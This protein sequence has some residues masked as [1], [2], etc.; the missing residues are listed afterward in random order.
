MADKKDK[1]INPK[2]VKRVVNR[3]RKKPNKEAESILRRIA[4]DPDVDFKKQLDDLDD[5][6][7]GYSKIDDT[8]QQINEGLEEYS[9]KLG[10]IN[11]EVI[12]HAA[13]LVSIQRQYQSLSK[14][15]KGLLGA[16]NFSDVYAKASK[17]LSQHRGLFMSTYNSMTSGMIKMAKNA[18]VLGTQNFESLIGN[19]Q[20]LDR[21]LLD[22]D[23]KM[24]YMVTQNDMQSLNQQYAQAVKQLAKMRSQYEAMSQTDFGSIEEIAKYA[25]INLDEYIDKM[26][27][28]QK[29]IRR[30]SKLRKYG[31]VISQD[32]LKAQQENRK[33]LG[34]QRQFMYDMATLQSTLNQKLKTPN[35]QLDKIGQALEGG[36]SSLQSFVGYIGQLGIDLPG[37]QEIIRK[38]NFDSVV[39]GAKRTLSETT[40]AFALGFKKIG[41]T[42]AK[43]FGQMFKYIGIGFH[44]LLK[45]VIKLMGSILLMLTGG[46]IVAF[47]ALLTVAMKWQDELE[48]AYISTQRSANALRGQQANFGAIYGAFGG[49]LGGEKA[50]QLYN[51]MRKLR[52]VT[53][54]TA[55]QGQL[56]QRHFSVSVSQSANMLQNMRYIYGMTEKASNKYA[57]IIANMA[58]MYGIQPVKVFSELADL[59]SEVAL[60]FGDS[61]KHLTKSYFFAKKL[62]LTMDDL[63]KTAQ[64]LM[65]I[66]GTIQKS[67][68][69]QAL[70]GKRINVEQ[71]MQLNFAGRTEQAVAMIY[72]TFADSFDRMSVLQKQSVASF[73]STDVKT[74]ATVVNTMKKQNISASQALKK[75]SKDAVDALSPQQKALERVSTAA[76][77][78]QTRVQALSYRIQQMIHKYM[79]PFVDII[80]KAFPDIE[81]IFEKFVQTIAN[82]AVKGLK[83]LTQPKTKQLLDGLFKGV[84]KLGKTL[85]QDV[86][87]KI[88]SLF[89]KFIKLIENVYSKG[90]IPGLIGLAVLLKGLWELP[91]VIGAIS[92]AISVFRGLGKMTKTASTVAQL[93]TEAV[94]DITKSVVPLTQRA[95]V[96]W[97]AKSDMYRYTKGSMVGKRKVGGQYYGKTLPPDIMAKMQGVQRPAQSFAGSLGGADVSKT[98]ANKEIPITQQASVYWDAKSDMY[99]YTKGSMVGKRKVGGQ[100]YGKTLPPDIMAKMQ[101]VQRPAQSFAGSLGGADVSKTIA[102]KEI[103]KTIEENVSKIS[104]SGQ[105]V[106]KSASGF[107]SAS[108][109]ILKFAAAVGIL[110]GSLWIV[111]QIP[112]D[113]LWASVGAIAALSGMVV[114]L[115]WATKLSKQASAGVILM[116]TAVGIMSLSLYMLGKIPKDMIWRAVGAIG[117]LSGIMVGLM[118]ALMALSAGPQ[119]VVAWSAIALF[120]GIAVGLIL[121][122]VAVEKIAKSLV[123]LKDVNMNSVKEISQK[124][125]FFAKAVGESMKSLATELQGTTKKQYKVV[126]VAIDAFSAL[127]ESL[128]KLYDIAKQKDSIKLISQGLQQMVDSKVGENVGK[129]MASLADALDVHSK[130]IYK[131][132]MV[133]IE[134][135]DKFMDSIAK[136]PNFVSEVFKLGGATQNLDTQAKNIKQKFTV[137]YEI[138]QDFAK[139]TVLVMQNFAILIANPFGQ[140]NKTIDKNGKVIQTYGKK[141][142]WQKL[143]FKDQAKKIYKD[144]DIMLGGFGKFIDS[145]TNLD[146]IVSEKNGV[147]KITDDLKQL[148]GIMPEISGKIA[149]VMLNL[150]TAFSDKGSK[151]VYENVGGMMESFNSFLDTITKTSQTLQKLNKITLNFDI[152]NKL[153]GRS[154]TL[155]PN[156]TYISSFNYVPQTDFISS[157]KLTFTSLSNLEKQINIKVINNIIDAISKLI[158][159]VIKLSGAQDAINKLDMSKF[160]QT[161]VGTNGITGI[162][163]SMFGQLNKT[164]EETEEAYKSK[165]VFAITGRAITS[166]ITPNKQGK[167]MNQFSSMID[168]L[169]RF[170][171]TIIKLTNVDTGKLS[172]SSATLQ[173]A[174]GYIT[175]SLNQ[176][177]GVQG[178]NL[179]GRIMDLQYLV[180]VLGKMQKLDDTKVN[181]PLDKLLSIS[182]NLK[183]PVDSIVKSINSL[184]SSLTSLKN[185]DLS[186]V[187]K[188][189]YSIFNTQAMTAIANISTSKLT[190]QQ[191]YQTIKKIQSLLPDI[192]KFDIGQTKKQTG[193]AGKTGQST[194][195]VNVYMDSKLIAKY[196]AQAS[197]KS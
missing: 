64:S 166:L 72:D 68:Q 37:L 78:L 9:R 105:A 148:I 146:K 19:V 190:P 179:N 149:N 45:N 7:S 59:S 93:T 40:M 137:I 1:D 53:V 152:F 143:G 144:I 30:I 98:I 134:G 39:E 10:N 110:A 180:N 173:T 106:G 126:K 192:N 80:Y 8:I 181:K 75:A 189:L 162:M 157:L 63:T 171:D 131:K 186:K 4:R 34:Q 47:G 185:I 161:L 127:S 13:H 142:L 56:L 70:T 60:Y 71:L 29:Q 95:S 104:K 197:N 138:I 79:K 100:Y 86:L 178:D 27:E 5:I 96:Y 111:A 81:S 139:N 159:M 12:D 191:K 195:A 82:V 88:I 84:V 116:A 109:A 20:E 122:S 23:Q 150:S 33:L 36:K 183:S 74:F 140:F 28:L 66:Q 121:V 54:E 108:T 175:S 90:G 21:K 99:R 155:N 145:L 67:L 49:R 136:L 168:I 87:P 94:P 62:N 32:Q 35:Q 129:L 16:L 133:I 130:K 101:G 57:T 182:K 26:D 167:S 153:F 17:S 120:N 42:G 89:A 2:E 118:V 151:K 128:L 194:I 123:M 25:N 196:V 170:V 31:V 50:S 46:F 44:S 52:D 97:D 43:Q 113:R 172:S 125:T 18:S 65:D 107:T 24:K 91:T 115:A 51:T 22:I 6:F 55:K 147:K 114:G 176:L 132:T 76:Y 165:N 187:E 3:N 124:L 92:K 15:A 135:F 83:W 11:D 188:Y 58:V 158:D 103:P 184:V 102:N 119:A 41:Q 156:E 14:F 154:S 85:I 112:A 61:V 169:N 160:K 48:Q 117:A 141:T 77:A 177:I 163:T 174:T 164:I 193:G 38:L 69:V 73:A